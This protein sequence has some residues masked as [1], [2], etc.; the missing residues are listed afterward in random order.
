M[1]GGREILTP[2]IT[3]NIVKCKMSSWDVLQSAF[4][5][6]ETINFGP[7]CETGSALYQVNTFATVSS[8]D[9]ESASIPS[10]VSEM[11]G[12]LF[13]VAIDNHLSIFKDSQFVVT[14]KFKFLVDAMSCCPDGSLLI[15]GDKK[16]IL[17]IIDTD[18]KEIVFSFNLLSDENMTGEHAF[19][20]ILFMPNSKNTWDLF[21]LST[22]GELF[23]LLDLGKDLFI[24]D[25]CDLANKIQEKLTFQLVDTSEVHDNGAVDLVVSGKNIITMGNGIILAVWSWCDGEL[26]MVEKVENF[27][28]NGANIKCGQVMSNGKYFFLLD[29]NE[30]LSVWNSETL[31]LLRTFYDV[32]VK[33]FEIFDTGA[34]SCTNLENVKIIM[35]QKDMT[36]NTQLEVR[37]LPDFTCVYQLKLGTMARLVS[38]PTTQENLC[39]IEGCEDVMSPDFLESMRF[40]LLSESNPETRLATFLRKKRFNEAEKFAEQYNLDMQPLHKAHMLHLLEMLSP[41]QQIEKNQVENLIQQLW[42]TMKLIN[43]DNFVVQSCIHATLPTFSDMH[44]L[45]EYIQIRLSQK[46]SNEKTEMDEILLNK[47][48]QMQH[49][50]NTF[51]FAIGQ[52]NYS[53]D[54]WEQFKKDDLFSKI[55]NYLSCGL[56]H[57]AF[58]IWRRHQHEIQKLRYIDSLELV[59]NNIPDYVLIT[60]VQPWLW[61]DVIPFVLRV[62][63]QGLDVLISWII[64]KAKNIEI[65][66]KADWP[67]NAL[68]FLETVH[69]R[70]LSLQELTPDEFATPSEMALKAVAD[71]NQTLEPMT[72][73]ITD[74]KNLQSLYT[75]YNCKMTADNFAQETTETI[76]FRMLDRLVAIELMEKT[77]QQIIRPYINEHKLNEDELFSKYIQDLLERTGCISNLGQPHWEAKALAVIGYIRDTKQKIAAVLEVM[78]WA[79]IPWTPEIQRLVDDALTLKSPEV[80]AVK[81]QAK[82]VEIKKWLQK[83]NLKGIDIPKAN[84]NEAFQLSKYILMKDEPDSLEDALKV[85]RPEGNNLKTDLY[86]FRLRYLVLHDRLSECLE[87]LK[88]LDADMIV[89]CAQRL[90]TFC[91]IQLDEE[92][93]LDPEDTKNK[94]TLVIT[95]GKCLID[96]LEMHITDFQELDNMHKFKK[97]MQNLLSLQIEFEKYPPLEKYKQPKFKE[98]MFWDYVNSLT[99]GSDEMV[100]KHYRKINRLADLLQ[101][102]CMQ[103]LSKMV[104]SASKTGNNE[105]VIEICNNLLECEPNAETAEV[106]YDVCLHLLTLLAEDDTSADIDNE[107]EN[108]LEDV[109]SNLPALIHNIISLALTA[110]N[111]SCLPKFIQ[112]GKCTWLAASASQHTSVAENT[113]VSPGLAVG[114][115]TDQNLTKIWSLATQFKEEAFIMEASTIIP[116]SAQT[117][118]AN[119]L[120][121]EIP[122]TQKPADITVC[123]ETDKILSKNSE[124]IVKTKEHCVH[125]V[126]CYVGQIPKLLDFLQRNQNIELAYQ[127]LMH[128]YFT[129]LEYCDYC[130]TNIQVTNRDMSLVKEILEVLSQLNP[131]RTR[132]QLVINLLYKIFS[133]HRIDHLYALA[134]FW[135]LPKKMLHEILKKMTNQAG[136]NYRRLMAL[137][138]VGNA[139][140]KLHK[141]PDVASRCQL[142]ETSASWGHQLGKFKVCFKDALY[143]PLNEKY[144][145]LQQMAA[146]ES[147]TISTVKDFCKDFQ[148]DL[149]DGLIKYLEYIIKSITST[150][151]QWSTCNPVKRKLKLDKA[152]GAVRCV[153]SQSR[154]MK[155]LTALINSVNIYD[156]ET[157]WLILEEASQIEKTPIIEKSLK[158]LSFLKEY[159]RI[160]T[161]SDYERQFR[162]D[163]D[164]ESLQFVLDCLP[165][166]SQT[167][168]PFHPMLFGDPWRIITKEL[169]VKNTKTWLSATKILQLSTDQ[170]YVVAVQN[171]IKAY[172]SSSNETAA[173][174]LEDK[175]RCKWD[176]KEVNFDLL[177]SIKNIV[178]EIRDCESALALSTYV[179]K[180]LPM[181]AEKVLAL[182]GCVSFAEKW[183]QSS[184]ES[185]SCKKAETALH[186]F[187]QMYHQLAAEQVLFQYKLASPELLDLCSK[188]EKL[189][190]KLYENS[191]ILDPTLPEHLKPDINQ[192]AVEI[193]TI[194]S[195]SLEDLKINLVC[196]WL[197]TNKS[198]DADMSVTFDFGNFNNFETEDK[199]VDNDN[200]KRV[201]YILRSGDIKRNIS[202]LLGYSGQLRSTTQVSH[203]CQLRAL[204]CLFNMASMNE[205]SCTTSMTSN[206]ISKLIQVQRYLVCLEKLSVAMTAKGFEE[207]NKEKLTRS[208]WKN[209]NQER[210][211]SLV[212]YLVTS[213]CFDYKIYDLNL[214]DAVLTKMKNM[215][216]MTELE[217][218]LTRANSFPALFLMPSLAKAWSAVITSHLTKSVIASDD[219]L[220][221]CFHAFNLI[222]SCPVVHSLNLNTLSKYYCNMNLYVCAIACLLMNTS[223]NNQT[224]FK[225]ILSVGP[226]ALLKNLTLTRSKCVDS[227]IFQEVEEIIF[228]LILQENQMDI[229]TETPYKVAFTAYIQENQ[230]SKQTLT[231]INGH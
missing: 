13:C 26:K 105:M 90:L 158:L 194:N 38:S 227:A 149:D 100:K 152:V 42:N 51:W 200:L 71:I 215:A 3:T 19:R 74:L 228:E 188:P 217:N 179:M 163:G 183:C 132:H 67:S 161:P 99:T 205:I 96:F 18:I 219:Q 86:M 78:K 47:A 172:V 89:V 36:G 181:G 69:E 223:I 81:K 77:L 191:S 145:V 2:S 120:L 143:G 153:K 73:L 126:D 137:A 20:R 1:L 203:M 41:W 133:Q 59:L 21:T 101:I 12:D 214:W 189:I 6:D 117:T 206:Q 72:K 142:M 110:C 82:L 107:K 54:T 87:L 40:R 208:I 16:G 80:E 116:L 198:E 94:R 103:L 231:M 108:A 190:R 196:E 45:L 180:E 25:D 176:P 144:K 66:E 146:C 29:E 22:T 5:G 33:E 43:D 213:L 122:V 171:T 195:L 112:L 157:L 70:C 192:M 221:D 106:L 202:F 151:N 226:G 164:Q 204:C 83:Y 168:L 115:R 140:G 141:E 216:M 175:F 24:S 49:R 218:V 121:Q 124:D 224:V 150:H 7:R 56:L 34:L 165:C 57:V 177:N 30:T 209:H 187:M 88:S 98:A 85:L 15:V 186:K 84:T 178:G 212:A 162:I 129:V 197:E 28:R 32:R 10:V 4:G 138:K 155:T 14:L 193:A 46:P 62:I 58:T 154:L 118:L 128:T 139:L 39:V 8:Q 130:T 52:K 104:I 148:I 159:K 53:S 125:I 156:Y 68:K 166:M 134:F 76:V 184:K 211:I 91:Y 113:V 111:P 229:V 61:E 64:T 75:K 170:L 210:N 131:Q 147:I 92:F 199:H 109:R 136:Q 79:P 230:R 185:S 135:G 127:Y 44:K 17:Y 222:Q 169:D 11:V 31:C 114:G 95:A 173:S 55:V 225:N 23:I 65:R 119:P 220:Q 48:M 60:N 97:D 50:L 9:K 182:Q 123:E 37:Q 35:L 93:H 174:T 201:A 102:P 207:C 167:R 160:A 63:P 27:L